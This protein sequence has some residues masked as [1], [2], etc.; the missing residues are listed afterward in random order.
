MPRVLS[1]PS[2][3]LSSEEGE[4]DQEEEEQEENKKENTDHSFMSELS[5][6]KNEQMEDEQQ[7]PQSSIA[8][9]SSSPSSLLASFLTDP[10]IHQL[11]PSFKKRLH[12]ALLSLHTALE[13]QHISR[14]LSLYRYVRLHHLLI[15]LKGWARNQAAQHLNKWITQELNCRGEEDV[16]VGDSIT[17]NEFHMLRQ[18]KN[19]AHRVFELFHEPVEEEEWW[20]RL[21][22]R[23]PSLVRENRPKGVLHILRLLNQ[24]HA[25]IVKC[26]PTLNLRLQLYEWYLT[27]SG[28]NA[29]QIKEDLIKDGIIQVTRRKKVKEKKQDDK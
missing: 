3:S 28:F 24:Y 10:T 16:D 6:E 11:S 27:V 29:T 19:D 12:S 25:S 22:S 4:E 23:I 21:L 2:P 13:S 26:Y 5:E 9:V 17:S 20:P 18:L 8:A 14:V 1:V 7:S 15:T